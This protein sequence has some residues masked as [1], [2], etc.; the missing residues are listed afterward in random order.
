LHGVIPRKLITISAPFG[1]GKT[2]LLADFTAHTDLPVCW[3]RLTSMDS[4]VMRLASV[5]AGSLEHSF[6][7]LGTQLTAAINAEMDAV[8]LARIILT[9]LGETIDTPVVIILD[10][11][12]VIDW[13]K[14]TKS[15]IEELISEPVVQITLII[16]GR[17][18]PKFAVTTLMQLEGMEHLGPRELSLNSIE[19]VALSKLQHG[20]DLTDRMAEKAVN[21][22]GGWMMGVI[23]SLRAVYEKGV[24]S[25]QVEIPN[26]Q[27]YLIDKVFR[28]QPDD[29]RQFMLRSSV[30]PIMSAEA[31]DD[32]LQRK[33]SDR[34]LNELVNKG[35]F[36]VASG[37]DQKTYE[38]HPHFHEILIRELEETNHEQLMVL[39]LRAAEHFSRKGLLEHALD[40]YLQAGNLDQAVS[41]AEAAA[42][43]M[44]ESGRIHTLE[45]W[46][47]QL[48]SLQAK[49]PLVFCYLAIG[50]ALG[51]DVDGCGRMLKQAKNCITR[52][53]S[54]DTRAFCECTEIV[55]FFSIGECLQGIEAAK[56][57]Q[58]FLNKRSP[59]WI[60]GMNLW[61]WG[62]CVLRGGGDI[63]EGLGFILEAEHLTRN[64]NEPILRSMILS[65]LSA[66]QEQSGSIMEAYRSA[67]QAFQE[68][69]Q[70]QLVSVSLR[71][72]IKVARMAY[73]VG[74]LD[75]SI[76]LID[77]ILRDA[78]NAGSSLR[79]CEAL[80]E[81][82]SLLSDL[83]IHD[84]AED[85]L[86]KGYELAVQCNESGKIMDAVSSMV[87][88][89][90][91]QGELDQQMEWLKT[92]P[93]AMASIFESTG[94][95]VDRA[96]LHIHM[97]PTSCVEEI[98]S[99]SQT[100]I[101]DPKQLV[102][103]DFLSAQCSLQIG[104]IE[105]AIESLEEA[106]SKANLAGQMQ[107]LSVEL[108]YL[109]EL[110]SLARKEFDQSAT[111]VEINHRLITMRNTADRLRMHYHATRSESSELSIQLLGKLETRFSGG[112]LK[113]IKPRALH[114]LYYLMDRGYENRDVLLEQF[115]PGYPPGKGIANLHA[116]IYSL[117]RVIGSTAIQLEGTTYRINP[118]I[119]VQYDVAEFER[120]RKAVEHVTRADPR[121]FELLKRAIES[122]KGP[123]MPGMHEEWILVR[124]ERLE[125]L[126]LDLLVEYARE[127]LLK[128]LP[129]EAL[130]TTRQAWRINALREDAN[131]LL[132][133]SLGR[134][135]RLA[136]IDKHYRHY[137]GMLE[138]KLGIDPAGIVRDAYQ[139][140]SNEITRLAE[141]D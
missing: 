80:I 112:S 139:Q 23:L 131:A 95:H 126:Y 18:T 88:L 29:I 37:E 127:A 114:I 85:C 98:A 31:C 39:R 130:K 44:L 103:R 97:D 13:A 108:S 54:K 137:V 28:G 71:A 74:K 140:W 119:P 36:I 72:K 7:Q 53:T 115:W 129:L 20:I 138:D 27:Q 66:A 110:L 79:V 106:I 77:E 60:R 16:S 105:A 82:G 100:A 34:V 35:L 38:Y 11:A 51:G 83:D 109:P 17:S 21:I 136:E 135:G 125:E 141:G 63:Q 101:L 22:T 1:S 94:L 6:P 87:K 45:K 30:M 118:N 81:K 92:S 15:F 89:G 62:L 124:R 134:L 48:N 69:P 116:H 102:L 99:V 61:M 3:V 33:D 43:D 59:R 5:L 12:H 41:L 128:N 111:M 104:D 24:E 91:R 84:E 70:H 14:G 57:A 50:L 117:R 2:T 52:K 93:S 19:V 120:A 132:I 73:L 107:L 90:C 49:I 133:E 4:D 10:D 122:Y 42:K 123:F 56:R 8:S 32:V 9:G 113:H 68:A 64:E 121:R 78:R 46:A 40:L 47:D 67:I 96:A 58:S 55:Y 25:L 86:R 75:E 76:Q 26:V 65:D